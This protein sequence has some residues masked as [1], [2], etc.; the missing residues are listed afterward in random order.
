MVERRV[1]SFFFFFPRGRLSEGG[2]CEVGFSGFCRGSGGE[3]SGGQK[4]KKKADF[5]I[6]PRSLFK[7]CDGQNEGERQ[8]KRG[9]G[10]K[11]KK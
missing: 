8:N 4:K 5:L 2:G 3:V 9:G 7:K 10:E 11:K 6:F 1:C